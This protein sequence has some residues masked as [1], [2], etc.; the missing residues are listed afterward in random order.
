MNGDV[1]A[2]VEAA[3]VRLYVETTAKVEYYNGTAMVNSTKAFT[4]ASACSGFFISESGHIASAGHCVEPALVR[5]DIIAAFLAENVKD[6]MITEATAKEIMASD[7]SA[8]KIHGNIESDPPSQKVSAYQPKGIKGAVIT[9]GPIVVPILGFRTHANGDTVLLKAEVSNATALA[10]ATETP[11][12]QTEVLAVGWPSSVDRVSDPVHQHASFESGDVSNDSGRSQA[13]VPQIQ[14]SAPVS[15]GMSGGPTV[16]RATGN[17]IGV[18]S[19]FPVGE[20]QPFNFVTGTDFTRQW[21]QSLGVPL[22]A[23]RVAP[24]PDVPQDTQKTGSVPVWLWALIIAVAAMVVAAGVGLVV[25][26]TRRARALVPVGQHAGSFTEPAAGMPGTV[27]GLMC[28]ACGAG[29]QTGRFCNNCGAGM[30]Q[31]TPN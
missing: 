2:L 25:L 5:N 22:V 1:T 7:L 19:F 30:T 29:N 9:D 11:K 14:I 3:M 23:A 6:N 28:G 4:V 18:N 15:K 24:A 20:N 21:F 27:H 13:G 12:K 8:W 26:R 16:E 10:F 31:P 17:V